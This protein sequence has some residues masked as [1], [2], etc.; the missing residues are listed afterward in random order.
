MKY[1]L[2]IRIIYDP[3]LKC[4]VFS[5]NGKEGKHTWHLT[6]DEVRAMI[7]DMERQI[8]Y[9]KDEYFINCRRE[10]LEHQ[11]TQVSLTGKEVFRGVIAYFWQVYG[12]WQ[13]V[14]GQQEGQHH[15]RPRDKND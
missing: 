2:N 11:L 5:L 15:F 12:A 9:N 13:Q 8:K 3:D 4:F 6:S 14:F 1:K 7:L 10:S